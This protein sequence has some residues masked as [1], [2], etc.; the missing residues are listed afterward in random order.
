MGW[1]TLTRALEK[2][3]RKETYHLEGVRNIA[4]KQKVMALSQC[5]YIR[6]K[7]NIIAIGSAGTGKTHI[8][9]AQ[10][11]CTCHLG[12][13]VRFYTAPR[14]WLLNCYRRRGN[15]DQTRLKRDG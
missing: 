15:T 3:Y 6:A 9:S 4:E 12:Y 7:E 13:R 14:N 5:E 8:C 2:A 10:T 1:D 11:L